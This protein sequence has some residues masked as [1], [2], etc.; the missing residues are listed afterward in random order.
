M[1]S[2]CEDA[3]EGFERIQHSRAT[4]MIIISRVIPIV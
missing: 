1:V 2:T 4:T 3:L